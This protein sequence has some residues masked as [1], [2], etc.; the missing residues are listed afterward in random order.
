ML[1]IAWQHDVLVTSLTRH[2]H[3]QIPW[4]Q[5]H[6]GEG[7]WCI[8]TSVLVNEV[9]VGVSIECIDGIAERACVANVFPG[10]GSQT[11]AQRCNWS[12]NR[13][14]QD[15][16]MVELCRRKKSAIIYQ[17]LLQGS[18]LETEEG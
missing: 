17:L 13:F 2:L 8:W 16:L 6:E 18:Y 10:Q 1:E 11:S 12:I 3:T 15:T 14:D 4:H 7:W 9:L 5:R